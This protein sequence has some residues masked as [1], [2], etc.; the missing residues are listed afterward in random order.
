V[1]NHAILMRLRL[2]ACEIFARELHACVAQSPHR[3]DVEFLPKGLHDLP[4]Q[5]MRV[6]IQAAVDSVSPHTYDQILLG[7]GLCNNGVAGVRARH[8]P[9]IVPRSHDCIAL[10]LGSHERYLDMFRTCPGTYFLS[11]GW[12]ERAEVG[13]ELQPRTVLRQLGLGGTYEEWVREFGEDNAQYLQSIL[14]ALPAGYRRIVY[15][16]T[17]VGPEDAFEAE[18][19]RRA[20]EQ[21]WAFESVPGDTDWLRQ[22]VYG[23]WPPDRFLE[24]PPGCAIRA[25]PCGAILSLDCQCAPPEQVNAPQAPNTTDAARSE[26]GT[27]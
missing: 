26:S 2:I 7:Y 23:P 21:G 16:R 1:V 8:T 14:G 18:A 10:L 17:G 3:V 9:L 11:P 22:L 13:D 19:R 27:P 24:V 4:G 6:R 25:D 20:V 5:D 12:I 15:I